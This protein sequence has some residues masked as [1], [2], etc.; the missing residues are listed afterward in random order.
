MQL[1]YKPTNFPTA[2]SGLI[3]DIYFRPS[4]SVTNTYTNL[5]I[6]IGYT[7]LSGLT[8]GTWNTGLTTVYTGSPTITSVGS[9]WIKIKLTTPFP[10]DNTKNFI[11]DV[12]HAATSAGMTLYYGT[13]SSGNTRMYGAYTSTTSNGADASLYDFGFDLQPKKGMNN[14][15]VSALISPTPPFCSGTQSV[16]VQVK[17]T[18]YNRINNVRVYWE[19]DAIPQPYVTYTS[20]IDTI[21]SSAGNAAT[22]TLGNIV[23]DNVP[24]VI[25]AYTS[26]P[27][28]IA[29][30]VNGDDTMSFIRR[31]S[32]LAAITTTGQITYC[33]GGNVNTPLNGSLGTGYTYQWKLNNVNIPGATSA[34]YTAIAPGT[35]TLRVDSG[36]CFNVSPPLTIN[37]L[38]MPQPTITPAN[39]AV[40]CDG[41]SLTLNANAGISGAA[42]QWQLQGIDIPGATNAS[43]VGKM[44]GNYIV[45][46]TK[47]NCTVSSPGTNVSQVPPP[48]PVITKNINVLST[49]GNYYSYQWYLDGNI[50]PGDTFA[51]CIAKVAGAY[52]VRVSNGGCEATASGVDVT[53]EEA[54]TSV[55]NLVYADAIRIYP[56]PVT[57]S[58]HISSPIVAKTSVSSI[59]GKILVNDNTSKEIDMSSFANGIYI[60]RITDMDGALLKTDKLIKK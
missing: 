12:N 21:G 50:L 46:T 31:S 58:V 9:N 22:V 15:S 4:N 43:Y 27:N 38:A 52:T 34:N 26:I 8:S 55:S 3:T 18:G 44:P 6:Q 11:V 49:A 14:A 17:N 29:D 56:N 7:T 53:A 24:H 28:G 23:L 32:P 45:K 41:D 36:A 30:T 10:Y 19:V 60:I 57:S 33:G 5:V 47:F 1:L 39:Y 59:D 51:T 13:S 2:P 48:S 35:Y 20:L 37:N 54:S 40:F 25:K 16:Q 42:Y